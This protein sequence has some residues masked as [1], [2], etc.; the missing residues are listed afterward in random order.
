MK[1]YK[2]IIILACLIGVFLLHRSCKNYQDIQTLKEQE[3]ADKVAQE[4]EKQ[5]EVYNRLVTTTKGYF[6]FLESSVYKHKVLG[7]NLSAYIKYNFTLQKLTPVFCLKIS[8][9]TH[10]TDTYSIILQCNGRYFGI[11]Y[12]ND[13]YPLS[14]KTSKRKMYGTL[15]IPAGSELREFLWDMTKSPNSSVEFA[16]YNYPNKSF[17]LSADEKKALEEVII[18]YNYLNNL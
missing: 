10:A 11:D 1:P 13:V 12:I 17:E 5:K 8:C 2:F 9:C 14:I 7:N 15:E 18:S 4:R 16:N 3:H 6:R